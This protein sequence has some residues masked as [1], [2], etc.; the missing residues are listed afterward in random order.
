MGSN[1]AA[2]LANLNG[3][4]E[5]SQSSVKT[6][7]RNSSKMKEEVRE[8][9]SQTAILVP[10]KSLSGAQEKDYKRRSELHQFGQSATPALNNFLAREVAKN[11]AMNRL[12]GLFQKVCAKNLGI[13][14]WS[15]H[16]E[17]WLWSCRAAQ[18]IEGSADIGMKHSRTKNNEQTSSSSCLL[19]PTEANAN[20]DKELCRKL[21]K[22]GLR[23][24]EARQKC[25]LLGNSLAKAAKQFAKNQLK[26]K[27]TKVTVSIQSAKEEANGAEHEQVCLACDGLEMNINQRHYNK[28][29]TL[30]DQNN[31]R[32]TDVALET[33]FNS[34]VFLLLT[35]YSSLSGTH[36]KAGGMQAAIHDDCFVVMQDEF[37]VTM[38]VLFVFVIRL[39]VTFLCLLEFSCK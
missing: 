31:M 6:V 23:E 2:M 3:G 30:Y 39:N 14:K 9:S 36:P 28:L 17:S 7:L 13:R 1:W 10:V 21:V 29:K 32:T 37:G 35:R 15:V 26:V 24:E 12:A 16:F 38:E 5:A 33:N 25:V 20:V 4:G 8:R 18:S 34:K 22:T 11:R 19:F 27:R